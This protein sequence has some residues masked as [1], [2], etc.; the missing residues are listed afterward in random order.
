MVDF[1]KIEI[2]DT[3]DLKQYLFT[4][5]GLSPNT[6]RSYFT[7]A[8]AF[9]CDFMKGRNPL[10]VQPADIENWY[11]FLLLDGE[12]KKNTA[13]LR[14]Q[15]LK[16]FY[17]SVTRLA[18]NDW[19][20]TDYINPFVKMPKL[21]SKKLNQTTKEYDKHYFLLEQEEMDILEMLSKI[22]TDF[23]RC[24]YAMI[25]MLLAHGLIPKELIQLC[26]N[27]NLEQLDG[28]YFY[29]FIGKQGKLKTI[30]LYPEAIKLAKDY[31]IN[32]FKK[33]PEG[34]DMFYYTERLTSMNYHTLWSQIKIIG[35][36]AIGSGIIK[37]KIN[38]TPL[39]LRNTYIERMKPAKFYA[40][41][42]KKIRK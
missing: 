3:E 42:K 40:C 24:I 27:K 17:I 37:R 1:S 34:K 9:F 32:R 18:H 38:F 5:L 25:I 28:K 10:L 20:L 11:D 22:T 41:L 19:G 6:Y 13:C 12:M 14:I 16:H 33:E 36:M 26:W 21:L 30:E 15:G 23:G 31:F 29:T 39:L 4:G 8:K 7:S 2:H 35:E